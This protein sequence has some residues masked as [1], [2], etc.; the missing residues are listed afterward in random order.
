[1]PDDRIGAAPG[2]KPAGQIP[3]STN[4]PCP[5]LRAMVANGYVGGHI[6]PLSKLSEIVGD[7]SGQTGFGKK[8]SMIRVS[9]GSM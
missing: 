9:C 3:V 2:A 8:K 6:V 1:M 7:A 4:N 5:F